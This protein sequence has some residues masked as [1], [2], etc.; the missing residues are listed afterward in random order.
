MAPPLV[1]SPIGVSAVLT[2]ATSFFYLLEKR[3]QWKLFGYF[4]SLPFLHATPPV[5]S[6]L[7][8]FSDA[9]FLRQPRRGNG[10]EPD[11]I[12]PQ[13]RFLSRIEYPSP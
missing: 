12:V 13:A 9:V 1:T 11:T 3:T 7:A 8:L 6:S 4:P 10:T 2:G 5:L